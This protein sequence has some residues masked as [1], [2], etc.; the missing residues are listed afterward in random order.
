MSSTSTPKQLEVQAAPN[1]IEILWETHRR[2]FWGLAVVVCGIICVFYGI[3]YF[4]Q[5]QVDAKWTQFAAASLLQ[6]G[7]SNNDLKVPEAYA[8]FGYTRTAMAL[9]ELGADL[10]K[11]L[12]K[13]D[14]AALEK[15]VAEADGEHKPYFILLQARKAMLSRKW[16]QADALLSKLASD[17]PNHSL[18]KSGDYPVQARER[19][20]EKDP[21]PKEPVDPNKKPEWVAA[22]AGSVVSLLR[23]QI[24]EAKSYQAPD[25]FQKAAIPSDAPKYKIEFSGSYGSVVIALFDK[26]APEHCKAIKDLVEKKHWDKMCVDEVERVK[27]PKERL[28]MHFGFAS[29]REA[30]RSKWNTTDKSEA[31]VAFETTNLSHFPGAVCCRP[32]ADDKSQADRLWI[33]GSDLGGLPGMDGERVVIG[34]VVEGLENI[35]KICRAGLTNQQEEE[36]GRGRPTDRIEIVSITA[37]Q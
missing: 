36:A 11:Q 34:Y 27:E 10:L 16:D 28:Q 37:V 9:G 15:A 18:V 23:E 13:T 21:D 2:K 6:P 31:E 12:N 19:V 1:Q 7:Y 25:H 17:Y 3:K 22:K 32:G 35:E 14:E 30:D 24:A 4:N 33:T 29:T 20:K 26:L 8:Q 5:K